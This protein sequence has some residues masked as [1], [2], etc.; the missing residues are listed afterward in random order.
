VVNWSAPAPGGDTTTPTEPEKPFNRFYFT[1]FTWGNSATL[2]TFGIGE[3]T[4][5]KLPNY[6]QS[7]ALNLRYYFL[8]K[9]RDKMYVN[10]AGEVDVEVTD[11][12]ETST[13]TRHQPLLSDIIV[14][15]GYGHTVYQSANKETKTTP[16]ISLTA[17][18]PSSIASQNTGKYLT[19]GVNALL[20]QSVGLA[21]SKSD[22]FPDVLAFGSV[23]YSHLFSKCYI[24]CNG[25]APALY[26][27]QQ[28]GNAAGDVASA[29]NASDQLGGASFAIDKVALNLTYY[30]SIYKDL[31]LGNTWAIQMPF[32]H[33]LEGNSIGIPTGQVPIAPSYMGSLNPQTTFDVSLS[34]VLFNTARV[35]LGYQNITP[36]L[37]DHG[38]QRI[39]VFYSLAGSAFYANVALYIDSLID[40]AIH[41]P[42]KKT[43]LSLGRFHPIQN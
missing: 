6:T 34:Y 32:K 28:A 38:G 30:L 29:Q 15:T 19:L 40:R 43:A 7:F 5:T 41:P 42:E 27:R 2:S 21:G 24:S 33:S 18:L 36:E 12:P 31:S 25:G 14:G 8:D 3:N 16:G 9:P 4:Q 17:A 1:R 35:D 11:G 39:S 26:P 20:V 37:N 13:T 10:V 23:G 22:W